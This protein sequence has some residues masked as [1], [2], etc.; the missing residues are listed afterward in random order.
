MRTEESGAKHRKKFRR[1]QKRVGEKTRHLSELV[2]ANLVPPI[3]AAGFKWV[4]IALHDREWTVNPYEIRL[5]REQGSVID[6][7]FILFDK[8][9]SPMFQV[10]FSRRERSPPHDFVRSGDLV[11]RPSQ[12]YCFWGKPEWLPSCL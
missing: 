2:E 4:D 11:K 5:E 6:S 10:G 7:I 1:W 12:R 3:E 8:Y 9:G